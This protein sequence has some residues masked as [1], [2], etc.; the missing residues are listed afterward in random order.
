M[1]SNPHFFHRMNATH[2]LALALIMSMSVTAFAAENTATNTG[3]AGTP[4]TVNGTYTAGN[5]AATKVS[6]NIT[7]DAMTFTYTGATEGTW[8]PATHGYTGS[9]A[10][11]WSTETA[12][13]TVT[14]HSNAAVNATLSFVASVDGVTGTFTE[15]SGTANDNVLNLDTAVGTEVANA[16]TTSAE[17]GIG[18]AAITES[19]T[20]GT[21]TVAIATN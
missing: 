8:D 7:W 15:T 6:V 11:G 19:K 1:V 20:L 13:I 9:T 10:G 5:A 3:T 21:I 12:T 17:F 4:I 2:I 14:N 18:G 16:P